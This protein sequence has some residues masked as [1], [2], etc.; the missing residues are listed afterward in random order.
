[1]CAQAGRA[2]LERLADEAD[3]SGGAIASE[4]AARREAE[5]LAVRLARLQAVTAALARAR[6]PDEVAEAALSTGLQALGGDSGVVLVQGAVGT[7]L[8]VLRVA[9][10][11]EEALHRSTAGVTRTP[12]RDAWQSAAPLFLESPAEV[13][14][15]YPEL[16][17]AS[18]EIPGAALAA[19]PLA[20]EGR[21]LGILLLGFRGARPFPEEERALAAAVAGVCGQALDR[22]RLFVA[23]RVARAE[24]VAAQRRLAFLDSLSVV[25]TETLDEHEMGASVVRLAVPS[26]GDWAGIFTAAEGEPLSLAATAGPEALGQRARSLLE[27]DPAGRLASVASGAAALVVDAD[28]GDPCAPLAAALVPLGARGQAFGALAVAS[29]DPAQRYGPQDLTLLSDVARRTALALE[30]ARLYRAAHLAAQARE[31][32]MHVASHELRGPVANF[33]LSVQLL[34]RELARGERG[35]VEERLR[36]LSRQA[37]RLGRLSGAL[38]DVTRITA[39]RLSLLRQEIDLGALARDVVA[40]HADEA[41]AA[42]TAVTVEA[43]GPVPCQADPERVEQVIANL[44]GNALKYGRGAPVTVKVHPED[45]YAVVAITDRGIGIPPEQQARIFGRFERAVPAR[46]Y[47]GL[48]LGLWIARSLVEAH[49][50]RISVESTPGQG[51]TF[52]VKLPRAGG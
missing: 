27:S 3:K 49:G 2:L 7:A 51:S 17:A 24:A 36:V 31:D 30:H 39:G 11:T 21:V 14:A 46:N 13:A 37:D 5:A 48:G 52:T 32:F 33:R 38:L 47:G 10:V 35:R 4:R 44:L 22:A 12:A 8:E 29:G 34:E 28:P 1:M 42:G 9:G 18:R 43:E 19:L 40:R 41:E 26:L 6:T 50:G 45:G 20:A 15:R 16:A 25:L 23:E